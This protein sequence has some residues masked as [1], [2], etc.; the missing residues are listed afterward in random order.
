MTR[1]VSLKNKMAT[2]SVIVGF[3]H[4][5]ITLCEIIIVLSKKSGNTSTDYENRLHL[6]REGWRESLRKFFIIQERHLKQFYA[7]FHSIN[8]TV[9]VSAC[10]FKHYSNWWK[11]K[12]TFISC[13]KSIF[14]SST[15]WQDPCTSRPV[16]LLTTRCLTVFSDMKSPMNGT[17]RIFWHSK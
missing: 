9:M 1:S 4:M 15:V 13:L 17:G 16:M 8:I 10:S 5:T 6:N 2:L 3:K 14:S 12:Q 7:S 11:I